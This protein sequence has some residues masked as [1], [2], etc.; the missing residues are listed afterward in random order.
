MHHE[1]R[2]VARCRNKWLVFGEDSVKTDTL[3][4]KANKQVSGEALN[5][6]EVPLVDRIRIL[7]GDL[8]DNA[9]LD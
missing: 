8:S 1:R 2:A 9:R 7:I 5:K 4:R 6:N 3:M